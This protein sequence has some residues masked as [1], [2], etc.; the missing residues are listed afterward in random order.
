MAFQVNTNI[1]AMNAHAQSAATQAKLSDSLQKLSSG[2]RINKASDDASGVSIADSLR[3]QASAL[4]QAARNTNEG[5]GIIQIADKAVDEQIKI[6]DTIKVRAIQ[7]AQDGQSTESRKA[8]QADVVRLIQSLDDIS[9]TTSYNGQNLLSGEWTNKEFQVGAYSNQTVR[10]SVGS[11]ASDRIGQVTMSTGKI[12]TAAADVSLTF[13]QV[14]GNNDFTFRNVK[15]STSAGTGIGLLVEVINRNSGSTGIKAQAS[16]ISTSDSEIV[17]GVL[18]NVSINGIRLGD[19]TGIQKGDADGRL[20]QSINSVTADTGVQAYTDGDG[21]LNLLSVDGRGIVF[22]AEGPVE[23]NSSKQEGDT[24]EEGQEE[25]KPK[26]VAAITTMNGG[27]DITTESG[28]VN[29][30]R[31][32]LSRLDARGIIVAS[33]SDSQ[34]QGYSSIGFVPGSVAT[35]TVNLRDVIN[36]FNSSVKSAAGSNSNPVIAS[37]NSSLGTGVT[38]LKGAMIVMDIAESAQK[39]L[40]RIRGDLGAAQAQMENIANNINAT[41]VN[42]RAAESRI[43]DVDFASA[44][45]DFNKYNIL[46]QSGSYAMSQANAI[47]QNVLKLLT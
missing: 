5:I 26:V 43:R 40:D 16:V 25:E 37:G 34:N 1:N 11:T 22:K 44:S 8:I 4:G 9:R 29:F 23:T 12:I 17:S 3:S 27:Q 36:G 6:L 19:I 38:T 28:S 24:Q 46:A 14:D 47:Q 13:K 45:A 35:T 30:G 31:L 18:N 39:A 42:L 33:A 41:Q 2:L 20:V 15:I 10:L 7:A 21:R 32:S